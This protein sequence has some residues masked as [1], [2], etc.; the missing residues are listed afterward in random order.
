LSNKIF[1]AFGRPLVKKIRLNNVSVKRTPAHFFSV[2]WPIVENKN[3]PNDFSVKFSFGQTAFGWKKIGQKTFRS[4]QH[5]F[6][7]H[8]VNWLFLKL[9]DDSNLGE[10]CILGCSIWNFF[11]IGKFWN[12]LKKIRKFTWKMV[13][14][15]SGS[16]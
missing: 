13:K 9:L 10:R 3:W 2:M 1:S 11:R 4:H 15:L 7:W 12:F 14:N 16:L 8:L 5:S 6:K